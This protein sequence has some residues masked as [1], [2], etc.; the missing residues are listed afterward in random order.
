MFNVKINQFKDIKHVKMLVFQGQNDSNGKIYQLNNVKMSSFKFKML[1]LSSKCCF[2]KV[3]MC[4]MSK[5]ISLK[6]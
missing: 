5:L 3:K 2:L 1:L 6:T 4:L